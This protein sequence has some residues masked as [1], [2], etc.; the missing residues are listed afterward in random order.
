M[1]TKDEILNSIES[2]DDACEFNPFSQVVYADSAL[3][4]MDEYA[5]EYAKAF[6]I[7]AEAAPD[8]KY[9]KDYCDRLLKDFKEYLKK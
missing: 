8:S 3:K 7:F 6:W 4:A 2:P 5:E 1:K 9:S